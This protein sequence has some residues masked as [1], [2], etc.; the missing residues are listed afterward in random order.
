MPKLDMSLYPHTTSSD[1]VEMVRLADENN[2]QNL[3]II[4]S[5]NAYP[6]VWTTA[7]LCAVNT[8]RIRIGPGVT[9]P[10]TRH[11]QVTANAALSVHEISGGRAILGLGT[12]DSA[13]RQIGRKPASVSLVREAVELCRDRF[14]QEGADIPIYISGPGPRITVYACKEAD[15]LITNDSWWPQALRCDMGRVEAVAREVGR[16]LKSLPVTCQLMFAISDDRQEAFDDMR[17]PL[18]RIMKDM[19]LDRSDAWPA[20]LEHLRAEA[21]TVAEAYNY[22]HHMRSHTP[23]AQLVTDALVEAFGIAGTPEDVL[24]KFKAMWQEG[25]QQD[26]AGLDFTFSFTPVGNGQKKSFELFLREI[27][28]KLG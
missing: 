28:P 1:V 3:W 2:I 15:G 18:T 19:A 13:V 8:S 24:P 5:Q 25:R 17:G 21:R 22:S 10:V 20:Q 27:L 4:D 11:P 6:N 9:N 16:D 26:T 23:S 12:G 14:K 7:T